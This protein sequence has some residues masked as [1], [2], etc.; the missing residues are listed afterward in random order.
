MNI[1]NILVVGGGSSGWM[2]ASLFT[3]Y[4]NGDVN[5]TLVES[6]TIPKVGVG[7]S[8]LINFNHF[9]TLCGLKD[10]DWMKACNATYKNSIKFTN[11]S[12]IGED[13]QYPFGGSRVPRSI[14]GW[15]QLAAKYDLP[16]SSFCQFMNAGN[17][18]LAEWNR[19]TDNRHKVLKNFD[20]QAGTAYHFDAELFANYL[21][22]EVCLPNGVVHHMDDIV[23]VEKDD[24]GYVTSVVGESGKYDADLYI[25]CSG[26]RSILLEKEMGSEFLSYKPWLSNDSA[27]AT[28]I[29]YTDKEEQLTNVTECTA[30][31]NGWVWN[32]PLW[33]NMGTGYC[34]SSDFVDDETALK[35]F[36]NHLGIE[37]IEVK[38]IDIKHGMRKDAWVKNVVGVGLAYAFVEPLESTSLISTHQILGMI[39]ELLER[40]RFNVN[41][42][43]LDGFNYSASIVMSGYRDF[44][45]HHYRLSSRTDTPYWKYH[46]QEKDYHN[47]GK[48]MDFY[49]TSLD[50]GGSTF[51]DAYEMLM[52]HHQHEHIWD[53]DHLGM[54]YIMAGMGYRPMSKYLLDWIRN[55]DPETDEKLLKLF[56]EWTEDY[57]NTE[58]FV[59]TLPSSLEFLKQHIYG[60]E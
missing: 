31:E 10:K 42:F 24:E 6:P 7:E 59:N 16:S 52:F 46:T 27:Y 44:V 17:Y 11:F 5:V 22:D 30:I 48:D 28:H 36:K 38:K 8:T 21:R 49:P 40:R 57:K 23:G 43:D 39:V 32:I 35:E 20:F 55:D 50:V 25:D 47:L 53:V 2:A 33:E 60:Y 29:P 58:K 19:Q 4:F 14:Y 9:L 18:L 3:K 54:A 12:K 51:D 34:Y 56:E 1:K 15:A 26:F 41:Q 37:D 13:F 45:S